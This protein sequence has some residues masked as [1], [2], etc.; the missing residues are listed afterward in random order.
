MNPIFM[1][2]I[3][4][5]FVL[6]IISR[7][8]TNSA[9]KKL[10]D[11]T[12]LKMFDVFPKRNMYSTIFLLA[13]VVVY[14]AL[15]QMLPFY[16]LYLTVGYM[17]AFL[18]YLWSKFYLNFRSLKEMGA[19]SDYVKSFIFGYLIFIAGS[20]IVVGSSLFVIFGD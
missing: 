15:F 20:M 9:V 13:L 4:M 2:G 16:R 11:Q 3:L 5:F 14:F 18:V 7:A 8:I 10:D 1:G 17:A 12:K 19:P 6:F